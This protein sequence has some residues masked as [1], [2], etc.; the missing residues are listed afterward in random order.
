METEQA[1]WGW[2]R[3][4]P[5]GAGAAGRRPRAAE[6]KKELAVRGGVFAVAPTTRM[7]QVV[8]TILLNW[9]VN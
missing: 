4:E 9:L 1:R 8:P 5:E 7:Q 3:V 2:D 6:G